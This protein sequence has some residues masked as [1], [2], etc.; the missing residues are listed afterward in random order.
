MIRRTIMIGVGCITMVLSAEQ[1]NG[2]S[3]PPPDDHPICVIEPHICDN[4]DQYM[5]EYMA[6]INE[7]QNRYGI[8]F[9]SNPHGI[10]GIFLPHEQCG[11]LQPSLNSVVER[12][13]GFA[14]GGF[15]ISGAV[16]SA[17]NMGVNY[18]TGGLLGG[19]FGS[20]GDEKIIEAIEELTNVEVASA[21]VHECMVRVQDEHLRVTMEQLNHQQRTELEPHRQ[22]DI[23]D[24]I[25]AAEQ[26]REELGWLGAY[27]A[28]HYHL[29]YDTVNRLAQYDHDPDYQM[30]IQHRFREHQIQ[31]ADRLLVAAHE[32]WLMTG[33]NHDY[34]DTLLWALHHE[35]LT[36]M[37][38]QQIQV[39][40]SALHTR[41][42]LEMNRIFAANAS[43]MTQREKERIE[44]AYDN[45]YFRERM[46]MEFDAETQEFIEA[47][48]NSQSRPLVPSWAGSRGN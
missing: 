33:E 22:R 48:R 39:E 2:Q 44:Q 43:F 13:L 32:N 7:I 1:V 35:Q 14:F 3:E 37:Q 46:D 6:F 34:I 45:T 10:T 15:D 29:L 12:G 20:S 19:I 47:L 41:E 31:E 9:N 18:L 11:D 30:E 27:I 4:W 23:R 26:A 16:D 40:L 36:P 21:I 8:D 38:A 5:Q 24:H 42:T 17:L 25:E 28:D